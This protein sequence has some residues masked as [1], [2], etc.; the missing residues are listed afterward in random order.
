MQDFSKRQIKTQILMRFLRSVVGL[1]VLGVIAFVAAR[2][3]YN[4]YG[5]FS[6]AALASKQAQ[7]HLIDLE[8]QRTQ[9]SAAVESFDSRRGLEAEIRKRYGLAQ[10]GEGKIEIVREAASTSPNS[11]FKPQNIFVRVFNALW[12]F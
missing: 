7:V 2:A 3:A 8:D 10:A 4:M 1:V 9:V 12:P 6:Q 5:K 11:T